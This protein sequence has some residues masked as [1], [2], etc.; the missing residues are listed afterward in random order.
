M[1]L[2]TTAQGEDSY[3]NIISIDILLQQGNREHSFTL[4]KRK[5]EY[6]F[7]TNYNA[8]DPEKITV[9]SVILNRNDG[10][11]TNFTPNQTEFYTDRTEYVL[12]I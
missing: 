1:I 4:T 3:H 8:E 2:F 5:P 10:T 12:S 11:S 9:K 6:Y 7:V